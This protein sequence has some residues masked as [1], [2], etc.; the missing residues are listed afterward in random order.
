MSLQKKRRAGSRLRFEGLE[1]RV[2]LDGNVT[3]HIDHGRLELK[4]D[5]LNNSIA[6]TQAAGTLTV[7]GL[8]GTKIDGLALEKFAGIT[9]LSVEL[10][11]GNDSLTIGTFTKATFNQVSLSGRV[12]IEMGDG[13]NVLQIGGLTTGGDLRV[14]TGSGATDDVLVNHARVGGELNVEIDAKTLGALALAATAVNKDASVEMGRGNDGIGLLGLSVGGKLDIETNDGND[15]LLATTN[16][17]LFR[18]DA[19]AFSVANGV[20]SISAADVT[21]FFNAAGNPTFSVEAGSAEVHTGD[22]ND[23]AVIDHAKVIGKFEISLGDGND[24]LTVAAD[25]AGSAVLDGGGGTNTLNAT[26][27]IPANGTYKV[28]SATLKVEDF[29]IFT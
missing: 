22:G 12:S 7:K 13:N 5:A 14:E 28:G 25:F 24:S 20:G 29:D 27:K 3:S 6:I 18:T 8:A 11:D 4:G 23:V 16:K 15:L 2:M 17:T 26:P 9:D 21:A 10:K 1:S 19:N